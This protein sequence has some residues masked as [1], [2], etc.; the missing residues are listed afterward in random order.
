MNSAA[1]AKPGTKDDGVRDVVTQGDEYLR[2]RQEQAK[3]RALDPAETAGAATAPDEAQL[4]ALTPTSD[5]STP[6]KETP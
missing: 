3:D 4:P 2:P 5:S 1:S 6:S